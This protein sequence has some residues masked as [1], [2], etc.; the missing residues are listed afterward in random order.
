MATDLAQLLADRLV[1]KAFEGMAQ[2]EKLSFIEKLFSEMSPAAQQELL[3]KL[4]RQVR[5]PESSRSAPEEAIPPMRRGHVMRRMVERGPA[6]FGPWQ[7]CCMM[8]NDLVRA[9]R[10][11]HMPTGPIARVFNALADETRL[12]IVKLLAEGECSV[13]ELVRALGIAQSTTSHH[14]RV[15]REAGLIRGDKRGRSIYYSLTQPLEVA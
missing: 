3:L 1:E 9:P 2:E 4:V 5:G 14:L 10:A 7:M 8:M 15:L 6:A 13:D 12:R 11:V